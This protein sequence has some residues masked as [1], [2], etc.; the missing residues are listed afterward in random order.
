MVEWLKV[1]ALGS[2]PGTTKKKI[3]HLSLS[4]KF[5]GP[6]SREQGVSPTPTASG[7]GQGKAVQLVEGT[8]TLVA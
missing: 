1:Q 4:R 2:N 5:T 7:Q 3:Y 6:L 8:C